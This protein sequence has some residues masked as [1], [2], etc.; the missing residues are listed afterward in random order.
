MTHSFNQN[1]RFMELG[2]QNI[3][4]GVSVTVLGDGWVPPGHYYLFVLAQNNIPSVAAVV[5]VHP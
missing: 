5:R 4:G 3:P 1:Q 2:F